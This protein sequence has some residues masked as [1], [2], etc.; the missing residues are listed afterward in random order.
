MISLISDWDYDL[1]AS[2]LTLH[3]DKIIIIRQS[4]MHVKDKAQMSQCS[5]YSK[6][7]GT[8]MVGV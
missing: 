3:S 6:W 8:N 7:Y 1:T 2:A 4:N 5:K